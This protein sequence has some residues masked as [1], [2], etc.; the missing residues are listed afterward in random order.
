MSYKI[1]VKKSAVKEIEALPT[2]ILPQVTTAISRLA[3][4]PRPQGC[5]KLKGSKDNLWRIRIG[6]YRVVYIISDAIQIID[7]QKVGHRKDI[8]E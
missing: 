3:D 2:K 1:V 6:D 8:Y 4:T 7:I 5:K